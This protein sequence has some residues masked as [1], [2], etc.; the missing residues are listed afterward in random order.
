MHTI[1]INMLNIMV[2]DKVNIQKDTK[3]KIIYEYKK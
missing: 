1:V 3:I 2:I